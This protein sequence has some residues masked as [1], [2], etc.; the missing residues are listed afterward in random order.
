M[1][2]IVTVQQLVTAIN[3]V[4]GL[5]GV[6]NW[7]SL[8]KMKRE[9]A[10]EAYVLGLI[11]KSVKQAGGTVEIV[12]IIS[13]K[14]PGT[15]V[16]RG[17]PGMMA[18]QSKDYSYLSCSIQEKEFEIHLSVQYQ[19]TSSAVHEADV[20]IY[21]HSAAE[22]IRDEPDLLPH[23]RHLVGVFECKCYDS[24]LGTVLGRTFIGLLSD[25]GRLTLKSLVSN[26]TSPGIARLFT[27]P[28]HPDAF[29]DL[30]PISPMNADRFVASVEQAL[31]KWAGVG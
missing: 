28:R 26:G 22:R 25:C 1:P 31:R 13:G 15:F 8:S 23:V 29:F 9:K 11:S 12:G 27:L 14:N 10:F 24:K 3:Q 17:A 7:L 5:P 19:G 2:P 21:K 18:S 16:C 20:S 4:M 6:S 30:S